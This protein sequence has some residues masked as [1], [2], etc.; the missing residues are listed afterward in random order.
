MTTPIKIKI[1]GDSG[2]EVQRILDEIRKKYAPDV[3]Q[4]ALK[5]SNPSGFHAFLTIYTKEEAS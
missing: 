2:P 3:A 5:H 1:W 4:S